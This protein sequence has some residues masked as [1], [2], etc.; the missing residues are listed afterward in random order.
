MTDQEF[1]EFEIMWEE[2]LATQKKLTDVVVIA[3]LLLGTLVLFSFG[4]GIV[5]L[6][7]F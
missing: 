4:I 3:T 2:F 6:V 5:Y 1:Y 7:T